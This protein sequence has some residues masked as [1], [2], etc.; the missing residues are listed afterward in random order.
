MLKPVQLMFLI[1][2]LIHQKKNCVYEGMCIQCK[3]KKQLTC[4]WF[5]LNVILKLRTSLAHSQLQLDSEVGHRSV[6]AIKEMKYFYQNLYKYFTGF[7]SVSA[8]LQLLQ[9]ENIPSS[10]NHTHSHQW[11]G[12]EVNN[13]LEQQL[14]DIKYCN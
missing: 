4:V 12:G 9:N 8:S 6:I 11:A 2:L 7:F 14:S 13:E 3:C 10:F 5:W 1:F